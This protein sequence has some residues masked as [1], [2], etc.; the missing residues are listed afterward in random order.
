[1]TFSSVK[2]KPWNPDIKKNKNLLPRLKTA[3]MFK[4]TRTTITLS[5]PLQELSNPHSSSWRHRKS[6]D[7]ST[8][9][10]FWPFYLHDILFSIQW[11]V[12]VYCMC[13]NTNVILETY[14]LDACC[15]ILNLE[16]FRANNSPL[17]VELSHW[18]VVT[19][20]SADAFT[21]FTP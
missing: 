18:T 20:A 4:Q 11:N 3:A 1:M 5:A 15:L 2:S 13:Y 7:P 10:Y 21:A 9:L 8:Q 14:F 12:C 19:G 17:W 6:P 16:S